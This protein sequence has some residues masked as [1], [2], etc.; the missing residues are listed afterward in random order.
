MEF[1]KDHGL[2]GIDWLFIRNLFVVFV[3]FVEDIMKHLLIFEEGVGGQLGVEEIGHGL[4]LAESGNIE[5]LH[6]LESL[7]VVGFRFH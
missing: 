7:L 1:L 4:R 5:I 6:L 2:V 3:E